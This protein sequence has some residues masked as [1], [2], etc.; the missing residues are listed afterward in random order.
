MADSTAATTGRG[1]LM[2]GLFRDKD[3]A[4]RA[5][6]SITNRGYTQDDVIALA[7]IL[8]GWSLPSPK[9][10]SPDGSGFMFYPARHDDGLKR[11]LGHDIAPNGEKEGDAALDMLAQSLATAHH[12]ATKLA[13]YF[14]ADASPPALVARIGGVD[15]SRRG[16]NIINTKGAFDA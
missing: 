8:T 9:A 12:L 10:P 15:R 11:F 13:Q 1:R 5:Y 3:S 16:V 2:T 6:S 4:E 7:R 14:V